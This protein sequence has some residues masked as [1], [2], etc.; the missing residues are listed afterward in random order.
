[1]LRPVPKTHM[2]PCLILLVVFICVCVYVIMCC[3]MHV[4]LSILHIY[5]VYICVYGRDLV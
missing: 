4:A 5:T 2:T 1:M 3:P